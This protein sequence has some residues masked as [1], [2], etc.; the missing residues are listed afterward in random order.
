MKASVI[1]PTHN[2]SD[3]LLKTLNRL[4]AQK[5]DESW[6]VIVVN[7]NSTD[8]TDEVVSAARSGFPVSCRL[9][10]EKTPGAAAARNAGVK[11]AQGQFIVFID[12]DILTEPDFLQ[13][14][15]NRLQ[16]NPGCWIV[17]G[18]VNLPEQQATDFGRF[19]KNAFSAA[20]AENALS[21]SENFTGANSSL[22]REDFIRLG[23]FD[24]NFHVASGEDQ[25]LAMRARA[26]KIKVLYD[27]GI[28]VEHNDW[29]GTS[30][31]DYC[32]RQRLYM[33][34]QPFFFQ[35]HGDTRQYGK[36]VRE[37]LPPDFKTD[38]SK[39]FVWKNVK[40][41]LGSKTGQSATI[42]LCEVFEKT[43]PSPLILWRLYRAAIAGAIYRGFQEGL[44]IEAEKNKN[45]RR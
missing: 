21:E 6:E 39:L 22:P 18:V 2:R 19:H 37:N 29:A 38:G 12:N 36:L 14:H 25:E 44:E 40:R 26:T 15:V 33:Q 27:S 8:D 43:L 3:A 28:V 30:I 24:E 45:A 5:F 31:R 11:I 16:E 32:L 7:N 23:G 17:G 10:H 20:P 13:R 4:A 42:G 1:I 9:V 34:T 35:K 41:L